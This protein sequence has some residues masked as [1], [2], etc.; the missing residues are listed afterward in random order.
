MER[1]DAASRRH[2]MAF[3]WHFTWEIPPLVS[4]Y[5]GNFNCYSTTRTGQRCPYAIAGYDDG[6]WQKLDLPHDWLVSCPFD[7]EAL[8]PQ[9]F[10]ER[11]AA[12]YRKEFVLDE[13]C[14]GK[15]LLLCFEGVGGCCE[16]YVNG[17]L[18]AR[19][20]SAYH[21]FTVDI[22]DRAFY[23][24]DTP[25][26]VAVFVD[27]RDVELWAYEGAGLYRQVHLYV[28]ESVHIAH[29]GVW[30][31]SRPLA[32]GLWELTAEITV[33]NS[34]YEEQEAT[35]TIALEKDGEDVVSGGVCL[36]VPA[37]GTAVA[38]VT[39]TVEDPRL[40][41]VDDPSLYD[42]TA[43][44]TCGKEQD[45]ERVPHG[46][47][48]F[49][50]EGEKGFFLNGKPCKIYGIC[51]HQGH[52]GVGIAVADSLLEFRIRKLKEM[53][54]NAFRFV[55]HPHSRKTLELCDRYGIMVMDENRHFETGREYLG[56]LTTM[57]RRDRNHPS[58]IFYALFNEEPIAA[59]AEGRKIFLRMASAIR[60]LD[61]TR[62]LTG[63]LNERFVFGEEG[64]GTVMDVAGIN[65]GLEHFEEFHRLHPQIP[66]MG[67]EN[68]A[69]FGTRG[70]YVTDLDRRMIA[71]NDTVQEPYF[72]SMRDTFRV[73]Q[74]ADYVSGV[75]VWSGFDYRGESMPNG[76]PAVA[77]QFGLMDSCGFPKGGY[78]LFRCYVSDEP[79][80]KM[81]QHWNHREGERI[82]LTTVTNGEEVELI[83]NGRS[84]GRRA[85]DRYKQLT[86][87]VPFEAGRLE[88]IAYRNG[89]AVA[90]DV[91]ETTGE[92]IRLALTPDRDAMIA[93]GLDVL[94]IA[95]SALDREG[96]PVP[97]ADCA[98][99]FTVT[100]AADF[101]GCGNGDPTCHEVDTD[102]QRHLF[103]GL[104]SVLIRAGRQAGTV[105]VT[106]EA[107]GLAPAVLVLPVTEP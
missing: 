26:C 83:L 50:M 74:S 103:A 42:L 101:L 82:P 98:V 59:T 57:V 47:R 15:Q 54:V 41:D 33:E 56:Y 53:G 38:A 30:A 5:K 67:V 8:N 21:E 84:L 105:T 76:W 88:A 90:R 91:F 79:T 44:L 10:V 96:R 24:D 97:T 93:D 86:W 29:D 62:L 65:Y 61:D 75:F 104:A 48:T 45:I 20:F 37:D 36:S 32:G 9:G 60:K 35:V 72:N 31:K 70:Q 64:V 100:G 95:V 89:V 66:L 34:F 43:R 27:R 80:V 28:K 7:V 69:T 39:L 22:T 51:C 49:R 55:H 107:E 14:R 63:A 85:S 19:N 2:T 81:L 99:A 25:N 11:G 58:V 46:F 52:A 1:F 12:W 6:A 77:S 40:W 23:G 13:A 16:V 106:A 3:D 68:V 78:Y 18:L 4:R 71:C 92:P 94:P 87:E 102:P 73:C 17:S